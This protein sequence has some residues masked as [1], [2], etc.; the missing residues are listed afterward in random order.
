[1]KFIYSQDADNSKY[2]FRLMMTYPDDKIEAAMKDD[3]VAADLA[4]VILS[5]YEYLKDK[6]YLLHREHKLYLDLEETDKAMKEIMDDYMLNGEY[7][8]N[9]TNLIKSIVKEND[10][11]LDAGASIGYFTM[12]MARKAAK[13]YA[14]EPTKNQVE[15]L[16]R[17]LEING[18]KNVEVYCNALWSSEKIIN[19]N[20]NATCRENVEAI[21]LDSLKIPKLD[22]IKM[23]ID[24]SEPE[25]LKGMIETIERSPDLK[26]V[27]EYYPAYM[28]K[29]GNKKED[30]DMILNKYF[31]YKKIEGDYNNEYW[32]YYCERKK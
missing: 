28:E 26:M 1:M 18:Y 14:F 15:Y 16:S 6:K 17:N 9:T 31:I 24:G 7:E 3:K 21:T 32:N 22:F 20:G 2:A 11:C 27:I 5:K 8:K 30:L 19:V 25:A 23:D 12:I 10:I 13:V 4:R 29:L